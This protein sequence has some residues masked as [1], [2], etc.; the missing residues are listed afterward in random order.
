MLELII[1]III[2]SHGLFVNYKQL[3]N[4]DLRFSWQ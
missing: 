2:M 1:N 4:R 3:V